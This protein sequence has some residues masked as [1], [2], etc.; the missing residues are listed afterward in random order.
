MKESTEKIKVLYVFAALPVGGAEEL[1]LTEVEGL[2]KSIFA[3]RVCSISEKGPVGEQ[4]ERMGIP[5]IPLQR[6]KNSRFDYRII[7]DLFRLIKKEG[8]QV[9]HTHLYDGGKYGRIAARLARVP[10][11]ISTVHNIYVKRRWKYHLINWVLSFTNDRLVAVSGA[12]KESVI[13]YDW[14]SPRKIQILYNGIDPAKFQ[15]NFDAG[16]IRKKFGIEPEDFLIGVVARLEEQKGHIYLLEALTQVTR[17]FKQMKVLLIGDGSLRPFLEERSRA[18]G[19]SSQVIFTGTQKPIAPILR[20]LNLFLLPSLWEGFSVAILEAM[21][22][23]L[24]V[25]AT[26]VGG[27]K[28]VITSGTNGVLIPAGDVHSLVAAI[29]DCLLQPEKFLEMGR[30]GK[31]TVIQKFSKANHIS[32][33]EALYLEIL[34]GKRIRPEMSAS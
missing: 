11:L 34:A 23:G 30:K 13:H 31:E 10:C 15:G 12:V 28:E 7:R 8:V 20:A 9:V 26:A 5:V 25:V 21:A 17:V 22:M 29:E 24:P 32:M 14:I 27:A 2:D 19:L 4:I 3:P 6:M 16:G 33:L 1:L 18:M